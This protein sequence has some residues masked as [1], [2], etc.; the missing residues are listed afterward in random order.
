MT[1]DIGKGLR[2]VD[3]EELNPTLK[4]DEG[5]GRYSLQNELH[6]QRHKVITVQGIYQKSEHL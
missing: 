5:K 6:N 3:L 2:E 4:E 1:G